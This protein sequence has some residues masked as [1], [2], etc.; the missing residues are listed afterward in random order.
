M[1]KPIPRATALE[2]LRFSLTYTIPGLLRGAF[3]TQ[4]RWLDLMARLDTNRRANDVVTKL[5]VRYGGRSIWV[6]GPVGPVLLVLSQGDIKRV[7]S[8]SDHAFSLASPE[9]VAGLSLFQPDSLVLSAGELR[10][11]RKGF[12]EAVLAAEERVHPL[13]DHFMTVVADEMDVLLAGVGVGLLTRDA[14]DAAFARAARRILFG[15][16]ARNDIRISRLLRALRAEANWLGLRTWRSRRNRALLRRMNGKIRSYAAKA[17]PGSLMAMFAQAPSSARTDPV[18][19]VSH[20]LMAFDVLGMGIM[21]TLAL[22]AVHP[23]KAAEA[24]ADIRSAE[25]EYGKGTVAAVTAMPYLKASLLEGLRLWAPVPTL[26]RVTTEPVD[27]HG[28]KLPAGVN[29]MIPASLH[30]RNPQ[31]GYA[32][33]FAP[34]AWISGE[35]GEDWWINPFSR[36]R[37]QCPGASL[38]LLIGPAALAALLRD[39][40]YELLEP[41]MRAD[42]PLPLTI[43]AARFRFAVRLP[44]PSAPR[45][46][47]PE[48]RKAGADSRPAPSQD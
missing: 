14:F 32:D 3:T 39:R 20:W 33:R 7:L 37:G 40:R 48:A 18:G 17:E 45:E 4:P 13:G 28:D 19:Q 12:N 8:A 21:Q 42:R 6:R 11:D 35:A 2:N 38:A 29:V 1:A 26:M 22:F 23:L 16:S 24:A 10:D 34:E 5:R 44:G 30:H 15:D 36:G 9:K 47:V 41:Q 25:E 31:L 27:W 43:N 46:A